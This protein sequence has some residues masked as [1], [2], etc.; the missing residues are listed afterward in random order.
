MKPGRRFQGTMLGLA[1]TATRIKVAHAGMAAV[2][3]TTYEFSNPCGRA[4]QTD[5]GQPGH[6]GGRGDVPERALGP[7]AMSGDGPG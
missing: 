1:A 2:E 4:T 7:D 6:Q 3:P 5:R